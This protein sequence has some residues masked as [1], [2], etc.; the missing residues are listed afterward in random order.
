MPLANPLLTGS[1][2]Q[3][4]QSPSQKMGVNKIPM[5]KSGMSSGYENQKGSG[6][7]VLKS[8]SP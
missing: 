8:K 7:Q 6:S 1:Q 2:Q 3:R 4:V 5:A